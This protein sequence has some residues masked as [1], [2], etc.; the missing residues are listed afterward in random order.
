MFAWLQLRWQKAFR[1]AT[2]AEGWRE[3]CL[4]GGLWI[5][6]CPPIGWL[7]ALGYRKEVAFRLIENRRPYL[8]DWCSWRTYL[9]DGMKAA[10]VIMVY[11]LPYVIAFWVF[12]LGDLSKALDHPLPI[13]SFAVCLPLCLPICMPFLPPLYLMLFPW[14]HLDWWQVVVL[15]AYFWSTAFIMPAAFMQVSTD[16]TFRAAFHL[17]AIYRLITGNFRVYVEAWL[18]SLIATAIA[19][20]CGPLAPWGIFGSYLVIVFAFNNALALSNDAEHQ[21]R[22][23]GAVI[24]S[25]VPS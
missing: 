6:L 19:L 21:R 17:R 25:S 5:L 3:K 7:L 20:L 9:L 16:K 22:F 8:P 13:L 23:A 24:F 11:Y 12:A 4:L 18:L 10:G 2:E 14:L 1:F 15:A